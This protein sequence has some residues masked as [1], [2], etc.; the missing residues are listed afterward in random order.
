MRNLDPNRAKWMR[1]RIGIL[2]CL[3]GIGFTRL[4]GAA[5]DL[6]V[7]RAQVLRAEAEQQ[8]TREV[9]FQPRRGTI[10]DRNHH[11][12]AVSVVSP[13]LLYTSDAADD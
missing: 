3:L 7:S 9:E 2:V 8:Y 1:V 4:V 5:W 10:Y 6:Q 13:C 11:P 12:L